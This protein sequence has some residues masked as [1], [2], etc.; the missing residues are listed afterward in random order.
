MKGSE[1]AVYAGI[2]DAVDGVAHLLGQ[3][4]QVLGQVSHMNVVH[5]NLPDRAVVDRHQ[6][7]QE[8]FG[9]VLKG[10]FEVEIGE[11]GTVEVTI[12]TEQKRIVFG[13]SR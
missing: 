13:L 7:P 8:Q 1:V 4:L 2:D 6:H 11:D 5:W 9:L 12:D 10:G 3:R